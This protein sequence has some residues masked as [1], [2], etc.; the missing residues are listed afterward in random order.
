MTADL[1]AALVVASGLPLGR[2]DHQRAPEHPTHPAHTR[3]TCPHDRIT[4]TAP[5]EGEAR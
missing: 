5:Y 2:A 3:G 4:R 1:V